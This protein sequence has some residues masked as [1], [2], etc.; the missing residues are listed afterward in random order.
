MIVG[1]IVFALDLNVEGLIAGGLLYF[2]PLAMCFWT[3]DRYGLLPLSILL[4][5]ASGFA[6]YLDWPGPAGNS[7]LVQFIIFQSV[8]WLA[9]GMA[10][11]RQAAE[12]EM[13]NR[14]KFVTLPGEAAIAAANAGTAEGA[15]QNCIDLVCHRVGWPVG[16]VYLLQ[17]SDPEGAKSVRLWNSN[18]PGRF[19]EFQETTDKLNFK[20]GEGLPG[21]V[22]QQREVTT[23][24]DILSE[25]A[26]GRA[27]LAVRLGIK[28]GCAFPV[29]A[30]GKLVAILE[31]FA[32]R[33]IELDDWTTEIVRQTGEQMGRMI[34][35]QQVERQLRHAKEDA[36]LAN[37]AK[38]EFLTNMSHELRTPLNAIIG[39]S[40]L[41]MAEIL[42]PLGTAKYKEYAHDIH[43]SGSHLLDLISDLLDLAK[44]EA[45]RYKIKEEVVKLPDIV[46]GAVRLMGERARALDVALSFEM[47]EDLPDL[48]ADPRAL[49]QILLNLISNAL[50]FTLPDGSVSVSIGIDEGQRIF[51]FVTDTGIGIAKDDLPLVMQAFHQV[52]N[53]ITRR[54]PGTGLGLPVVQ[55]LMELHGGSLELASEENIG[56]TVIVR[57]PRERTVLSPD[58]AA[59]PQPAVATVQ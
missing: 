24:Q 23:V 1:A 41:L 42:G 51:L 53:K 3:L 11:R 47:P 12:A 36:E 31:F 28:G 8:F 56:T 4:S 46:A 19:S 32:P 21:R 33:K 57:F 5:G 16:H 17:G 22:F 52:D 48:L 15:F 54:E 43:E 29:F 6:F 50:K 34:E 10:V 35:R 37:S 58:Q 27:R 55:S 40:E 44:I 39:F 49:K 30:A 9:A 18:C 26:A 38:S 45:H 13:N 25:L 20:S 7:D 59:K 2:I 14:T